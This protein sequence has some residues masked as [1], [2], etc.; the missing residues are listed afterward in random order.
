M[1]NYKN[2]HIWSAEAEIREV[3]IKVNRRR[4]KIQNKWSD[5]YFYQ[6]SIAL[7]W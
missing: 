1:S 2:E 5:L 7:Q 3:E 6:M 4:K